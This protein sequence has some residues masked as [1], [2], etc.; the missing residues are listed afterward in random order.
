ML[1]EGVTAAPLTLAAGSIC[2]RPSTEQNVPISTR[3]TSEALA[4]K[5]LARPEPGMV[6]RPVSGLW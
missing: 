3:Q 5:K 4:V 2:C 6:C 1:S